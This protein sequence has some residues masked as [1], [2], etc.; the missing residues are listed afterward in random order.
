LGQYQERLLIE[1]LQHKTKPVLEWLEQTHNHWEETFWRLLAKNFG[2]IVNAPAFESMACNTPV[3][4][5][6]KNKHSQ[7]KIESLLMGQCSLLNDLFTD[8]YPQLL[9]QEYRLLKV[10]YNLTQSQVKILFLRM[11][12]VS[13]PTIRLSQLAALV[14]RSQHLFSKIVETDDLNSIKEMFAVSANDYWL[15]HYKFDEPSKFMEKNLGADMIDNIIINTVI[16]VLFAYGMVK[17]EMIYK[18][19][20]LRWMAEIPAE[21]NSIVT[22]F[23]NV[24]IKTK[25]AAGSQALIQLKNNYCRHKRCLEC[26]VGNSLLKKA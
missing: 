8:D 22:G 20:A 5:L 17:N 26:T 7:V 6:A 11:R 18:E 10:K 23:K 1:R 21:K 19:R 9:Q 4:L 12:P 2:I 16:P 13:F 15:Y 3:T 14:F 24:G 25:N